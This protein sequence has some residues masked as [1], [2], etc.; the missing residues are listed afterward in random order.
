MKLKDML[1]MSLSNLWKRRV[2]TILTVLG[3]IIG[4]SS[5]VVMMSLGM[6]LERAM[7]S[8]IQDAASMTTIEVS[9]PY[10]YGS[11]SG[12]ESGSQADQYLSDSTVES[13]EVLDHVSGAYPELQVDVI[14]KFGKYICYVNLTGLPTEAM[15]IMNIPLES[16]ELPSDENELTF[17]YGNM[18]LNGYYNPKTGD[19]P[20]YET[21]ETLDYDLMNKP[22]QVYLDSDAYWA[23]QSGTSG[24]DGTQTKAPKKYSIKTAGV[25]A[26]GDSSYNSFS[27]NTYCNLEALKKALKKEFRNEAIPGQPTTKSGKAYKDI[28]YNTILVVVDDFNNVEEVQQTIQNMGYETYSEAEWIKQ[29]QKEMSYI[30]AVLGGIGAVSLLVA[31]IGIANTMMMSIYERTKEIGIMKVLG[32]DMK[33]IGGMF[34]MEAGYIGFFGGVIGLGFSFLISFVINQVTGGL[35]GSDVGI[36]YIPVWLCVVTILFAVLIGMMA[37]YF[38]ARRAMK[39]S[40]LA[41]IKTE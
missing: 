2:R 31:A 19:S 20:Y 32:C 3:V 37:G 35:Y 40:P 4:V 12:N 1:K 15:E 38:P 22:V 24:E 33:N 34:L 10:D 16:G 28:Y 21:G 6:G 8:E 27:W 14:A 17:L 13:L 7:L 23:M 41:A 36:S 5:I 18:A 25:V 30:E 11:N 39:L 9:A 26:G 29:S